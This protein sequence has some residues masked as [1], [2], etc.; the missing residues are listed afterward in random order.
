VT[1]HKLPSAK[2]C[3]IAGASLILV[4]A[5]DTDSPDQSFARLQMVEPIECS[6]ALVRE[7]S[8]PELISGTIVQCER[9]SGFKP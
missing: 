8:S 1:A 3:S 6:A 4:P 9:A 2:L 5:A 7:A